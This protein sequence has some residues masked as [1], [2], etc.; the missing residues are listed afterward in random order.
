MGKIIIDKDSS[1]TQRMLFLPERHPHD[2]SF[3]NVC[4]QTVKFRLT[5][6]G[7]LSKIESSSRTQLIEFPD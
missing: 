1:E 5:P 4:S 6:D 2:Q 7:D 3:R